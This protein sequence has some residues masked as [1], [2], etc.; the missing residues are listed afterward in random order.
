[1]DCKAKGARNERRSIALLESAGY[2]CTRS[3]ASLGAWDVIGIGPTD[4]ILCQVKTGQWPGP[5][6]LETLRDFPAASQC[7]KLV[8]RWMP[9]KRLPD[10]RKI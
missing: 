3:G 1:M 7:K 8:H 4:V 10:V 9:G 2:R 6:E 5:G